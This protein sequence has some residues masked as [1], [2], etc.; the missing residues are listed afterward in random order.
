MVRE[1]FAQTPPDNAALRVI[2]LNVLGVED[3]KPIMDPKKHPV[4]VALHRM[5][6]GDACSLTRWYC[7]RLRQNMNQY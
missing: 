2:K 1:H 6:S 5:Y 3:G 4:F 7:S